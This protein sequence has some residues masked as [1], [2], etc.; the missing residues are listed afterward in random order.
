MEIITILGLAGLGYAVTQN[1][2]KPAAAAATKPTAAGVPQKEG[3]TNVLGHPPGA[4]PRASPSELDLR[5]QVGDGFT[6]PAQPNLQSAMGQFPTSFSTRTATPVSPDAVRPAIAMNS[7]G[8]EEPPVYIDGDSIVSPLSGVR[9]PSSEF[10]HINMQ[11]FYGGRVKQNMAA[12]TNS[13]RLDT[14]TGAGNTQI[15]KREVE[16]M[17]D[18]SKT[19]F[20]NPFGLENSSE[21]LR[22][23]VDNP[24]LN[25]REGERPFEP[26]RIGPGIGEKFGATGKG[27]FQQMEVNDYMM[28]AMRRTDDLRTADNPKLTYKGVVVP[29]QQFIGKAMDTPGEVRKYRPDTYY[30][31]NAGER[32]VGAFSEESQKETSR[33]LQVLPYTTRADTSA[34]MIGPAASQESGENYVVGSYRAPTAQQY[35][36]AGY[37]NAD[38]QN[39]TTND[40]SR[41]M[42]DYGKAGYEARPNER[43][44]TGE[45]VMGLNVVPAEHQNASV[46]YGDDARPTRRVETE[47]NPFQAGMA[48]GYAA[49]APSITVWD[50]SDVARTTVKE[51]TEVF[52]YRGIAAPGDFPTRLKVY[53]PDDIARPTQKAQLSAKSEYFGG[54]KAA[55]EK[56]T[57]HQAAYNMRLN[58]NKT[59]KLPAP[60]AGNGGAGAGGAGGLFNSGVAQ[61]ARRL[62]TDIINDRAFAVNSV[63]GLPP[64]AGDIGQIKYRAV[65]KMDISRDRNQEFMVSAV[66]DNP[67]QQSLQKNAEHDE[68][69]LQQYLQSRA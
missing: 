56:F 13:S 61:T 25:R 9:M 59:S 52:D 45:R 46:R 31:D 7:A 36:G 19:P 55:S 26:S 4:S 33:P 2:K 49:T 29:G 22:E 37:R 66:N 65:P 17:F 54:V 5:Y 8:I 11:P 44:Y 35:S 27:G 1:V 15:Q 16:T 41:P 67:L 50:P 32:F 24:S 64:G 40:P 34:E 30:I 43:Y 3:Y 20:G 18:T 28:K 10:T 6:Y 60:M 62:N 47:G 38:L 58:P 48:T 12:D 23:R 69:F 68:M 39:F 57:S 42:A 14:Y 21:F 51:T 63:S 53:D